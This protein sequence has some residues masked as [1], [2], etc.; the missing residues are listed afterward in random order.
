MLASPQARQE[1]EEIR[2]IA[3]EKLELLG[4]RHKAHQPAGD[5]SFGEAK[6]LEI[7]RAL[8]S[9]PSLLLMDEPVAGVPH[10]EVSVVSEVIQEIN[11]QGI[12]VLLV[13]HNMGFVMSL[14]DDIVVLNYGKKIAEGSAKE[15][16]TN[17]EVLTAYLGEDYSHA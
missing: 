7:A 15:V 5:L 3:T 12:S 8:A 17:P 9:N 11:A 14:C 13:E 10:A 6:I 16:R 1:E 2:V 4:M